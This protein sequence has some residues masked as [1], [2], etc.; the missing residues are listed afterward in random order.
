MYIVGEA[1]GGKKTAAERKTKAGCGGRERE[2]QQRR[3]G[4]RR[5]GDVKAMHSAAQKTKPP[6]H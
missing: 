4:P 5:S 1:R 3:V 2:M 6:Y